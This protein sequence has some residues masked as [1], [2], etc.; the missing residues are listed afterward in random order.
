MVKLNPAVDIAVHV[1]TVW[2]RPDGSMVETDVTTH[3]NNK[4][5]ITSNVTIESF[6]NFDSGNYTC[7]ATV[8]GMSSQYYVDGSGAV[9]ANKTSVT[10]GT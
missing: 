4:N 5:Y 10:T 1:T 7:T 6:R 2:T 8:I 9:A 3:L